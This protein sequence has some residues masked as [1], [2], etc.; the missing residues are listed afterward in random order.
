[1]KFEFSRCLLAAAISSTLLSGAVNADTAKIEE[2]IVYGEKQN[3][4]LQDS[5]VSVGIVSAD[6]LANSTVQ[7]FNDI[8]N[9]VANVTSLRGGNETLFAIRG[10]SVQGLSDNP[11]NFTAGVYVDEVPLDNLSIRY[12][13]MNAWDIQQVEVYRGPQSTLQGRNALNGA[14]FIKTMDPSYETNGRAR[15]YLGEYGT[16][17]YSVAGGTSIIDGELAIRAS[18][19]DHSSDSFVTNVTRGEKD[20]GGFDRATGRVKVLWE[21]KALDKLSALV[22]LART[23][24]DVGDNPVSRYDDPFSFEAVSDNEAFHN[25]VTDT[26]SLKLTWQHSDNM[27]F[28]S[29]TARSADE[30]RRLDDYDSSAAPLGYIDQAG[31]SEILSQEFRVNFDA[32]NLS[33][34]AGIYYSNNDRTA[35]WDL[36][37]PYPKVNAEASA[38]MALMAPPEYGGFGLD[39]ATASYIW[40]FV[41]DMIDVQQAF[42]SNYEVQNYAV[43]GELNYQLS[44]NLTVTAGV[45]YDNENQ[46][47][48]QQTITVLDTVT[49][50]PY[51]TMLLEALEAQL[52]TASE[53]V[54]TDYNAV[55][56]KVAIQYNVS[57][58]SMLALSAQKGYRAGGSTVNLA[59]GEVVAF[60]P[61]YT[62]NYELASRTSLSDF[63]TIN[64]NV[65]YTD[66]SDQQV[67]VSPSGDPIDRYT[68]NA[69]ESTLYG[70]EVELRAA[71]QEGLEVFANAGYV[72]TEYQS[73]DLL[74]GAGLESFAGNEFMGAPNV[75]TAAGVSYSAP[76]NWV[77]S[78]DLNYQDE[79]Y[80]DNANTLESDARVLMNAKV[81]YRAQNWSA[82]VWVTNLTD[83]E[84]I[85][86]QYLPQP[87]IGVQDYVQAGAPR[88]IGANLTVNF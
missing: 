77:Y 52:Q 11:N 4:S 28:T 22:T 87:G 33:G 79:A 39:Y 8:Y 35:V 83:K 70:A 32:N 58:T 42:D 48:D 13:V 75:T 78:F 19:D 86:N 40:S 55:L 34:V 46:K 64:A 51:S 67:D 54:D 76:N 23:E 30:Y 72:K 20:Y 69:G 85:V 49:G 57:D 6:D 26:A 60:D 63:A 82:E 16:Q 41:P 24:N 53:N 18:Y 37:T 3:R 61:E 43:F 84:Y 56:P 68:G 88:M 81:G 15:V 25:I 74:T 36:A 66:W 65:F 62:W 31:E 44:D 5:P 80:L 45:R 10:I 50:E 71:L 12:G 2:I 27:Y 7:D 21:P 47:R 14:V 59:S 29:V 9:R 1:M 17:R 73:F 38:F